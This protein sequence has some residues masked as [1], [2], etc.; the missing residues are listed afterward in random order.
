MGV[1]IVF[2]FDEFVF[3]ITDNSY[4]VSYGTE[5]ISVSRTRVS[6]LRSSSTRSIPQKETRVLADAG[7]FFYRVKVLFRYRHKLPI[8]PQSLPYYLRH[9][10]IRVMCPKQ[11]P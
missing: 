10:R 8:I 2:R 4:F 5:P 11:I 6:S 9:Y 1:G 7:F 3:L